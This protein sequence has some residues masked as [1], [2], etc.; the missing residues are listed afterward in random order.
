[1]AKQ[2]YFEVAPGVWGMKVIFVNIYMIAEDDHWV[3]V[4]AGLPGSARRILRMAT[5]LFGEN[6]PP[7]AIILTHG[8]FDHR[9]GLETLLKTWDVPIYVHRMELPYLNGES[10]Y[11]PADPTVGGGLMSLL[12]IFY[13][14]QPLR[15]NG[16][17][18]ALPEEGAVP[19]L[20][21][22][23]YIYTPG[24]SAGH[25]SL[26]RS[27][28]KVLIA[29]DAFVTTKQESAI[30]AILQPK[31]ISGPP[32]YFTPDWSASRESV[33]KLRDL[34]PV[35]A[36]TGHGVPM[37]GQELT[38]GLNQLVDHFDEIAVPR[39]GRYVQFPAKANKHG[40]RY[41]PPVNV[42]PV[43]VFAVAAIA[44]CLT[45][46]AIIKLRTGKTGC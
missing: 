18:Q 21:H 43:A 13:P 32:K 3:L 12:S 36:A 40:V 28:G 19:F 27:T 23:L 42:K 37:K 45:V 29:G 30:C 5:E 15:L 33:K 38:D 25:I 16:R 24:H 41:I 7:A 14:R 10:A 1:M 9:G 39:R 35:I 34:Q 31:Y 46:I 26:F 2:S 22:W 17:V 6:N 20:Q 11:P 44:T 8:H 4:D